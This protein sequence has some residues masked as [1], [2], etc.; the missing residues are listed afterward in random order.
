M[1]NTVT[2]QVQ[3][4]LD[5]YLAEK[6]KRD[7]MRTEYLAVRKSVREKHTMLKTLVQF[8]VVPANVLGKDDED[9]NENENENEKAE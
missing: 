7:E 4:L 5:G 6:A 2:P 9:E 3:E 8:G 1:A